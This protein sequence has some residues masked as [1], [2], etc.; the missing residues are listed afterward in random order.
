MLN[1]PILCKPFNK[2]CVKISLI[3]I[4]MPNLQ[5]MFICTYNISLFERIATSLQ[6]GF[7]PLEKPPASLGH[8]VPREAAH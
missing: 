1:P 5:I 6:Q 8:G 7:D 3:A 4:F 2:K